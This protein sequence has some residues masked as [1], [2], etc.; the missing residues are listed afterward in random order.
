MEDLGT[1]LRC[2][3][4]VVVVVGLACIGGVEVVVAPGIH[5]ISIIRWTSIIKFIIE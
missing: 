1:S 5:R 3:V 2:H 4:V